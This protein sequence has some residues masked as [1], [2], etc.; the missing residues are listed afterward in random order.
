MF[1]KSTQKSR[2][3]FSAKIDCSFK[4]L[5]FPVLLVV[6][7]KKKRFLDVSGRERRKRENMLKKRIDLKAN[8]NFEFFC[9]SPSHYVRTHLI[10]SPQLK[11]KPF[12]GQA[13]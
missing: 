13:A 4:T 2:F 8:L 12:I 9:H 1:S 5:P 3:L 11:R 6:N 10:L 7:T